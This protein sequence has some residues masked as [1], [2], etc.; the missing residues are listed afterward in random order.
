MYETIF[1]EVF[2]YQ[3]GFI[4]YVFKTLHLLKGLNLAAKN[5]DLMRNGY[6]YGGYNFL[7]INTNFYNFIYYE[8]HNLKTYTLYCNY[9]YFKL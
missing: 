1:F 3:L 5:F 8:N 9:M 4:Y 7:K 2:I 6:I